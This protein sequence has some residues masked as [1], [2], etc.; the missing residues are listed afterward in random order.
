MVLVAAG[1]FVAAFLQGYGSLPADMAMIVIALYALPGIALV[2]DWVKRTQAN[3]SWLF[4]LYMTMIIFAPQVVIMLAVAGFIDA[5]ADLRR[6][7]KPADD[8]PS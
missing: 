4:G 1:L 7:I 6:W 3:P 8:K 2:H 5:W